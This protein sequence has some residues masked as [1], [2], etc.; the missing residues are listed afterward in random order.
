MNTARAFAVRSFLLSSVL[1]ALVAGCKP[2]VEHNPQASVKV[3]FMT[4]ARSA[5]TGSGAPNKL[6][7]GPS[8]GDLTTNYVTV[9]PDS[10]ITLF[11]NEDIPSPATGKI[12]TSDDGITYYFR[13]V[14]ASRNFTLSA[15][16]LVE[17]YCGKGTDGLTTSNGQEGFGIMAR[18]WVPQYPGRTIAEVAASLAA[19]PNA[20]YDTG[21]I[22]GAGRSNMI[23]VGGVKRGVRMAYRYGVS[24]PSG[25]CITNPTFDWNSYS[26]TIEMTW[27]P[28]E[29]GDYSAYPTLEDRPDFPAKNAT[30]RLY[31]RKTNSGFVAK[32]TPPSD[33]GGQSEY[34]LGYPDLLTATNRDKYYVGFFAA[35]SAQIKVSNIEYFEAECVDEAP[36]VDPAALV[37]TPSF[38]IVSP[39]ANSDGDYKLYCAANVKGHVSVLQDGVAVKGAENL[40]CS[41]ISDPDNGMVVPFAYFDIPVYKLADGDNVFQ[42][43]FYPG[44]D[45]DDKDQ[46]PQPLTTSAS[47]T[48]TIIVAKRSFFSAATPLYV[49]PVGNS[50]NAGTQGSPLDL[51]TAIACVLPGQ[52]ILMEDGS[53]KLPSLVIPRYNNGLYGKPKT[54]K[55]INRDQAF[56]DFEK[57]LSVTNGVEL[58]GNYWVLSGFHVRN[59]PNKVKGL[60]V[61]GNNNVI[62]WVKAYNNGDTGLQFSGRTSEPYAFWPKNNLMQYCEA[63]NNKDDSMADADGFAAKITVGDGNVFNWCVSHNNADDGWD[64]FAKKETGAIGAVTIKNCISYENGKLIDG[65]PSLS[66]RNG[67]KVGGE[68]LSTPHVVTNCL[69][70]HN[71]AHGFTSNSNPAVQFTYCSSIDNGGIYNLKTNSDS[72]NFTIYDGSN[73]VV[74]LPAAASTAGLLSLYS[75]DNSHTI[76]W[77]QTA[78]ASRK[79]DK[80]EITAAIQGYLWLG[81]DQSTKVGS[82][83]GVA[84]MNSNLAQLTIADLVSATLPL[85]AADMTTRVAT[86]GFIKRKADG[87][88][89]AEGFGNLK[90]GKAGLKTG[91]S[92]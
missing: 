7:F 13:E 1:V 81:T 33:K 55:A 44:I 20:S 57:D 32:I 9:N 10:T 42:V 30:Y 49:S 27:F 31:L 84:T 29:L 78:G 51:R 21:D 41:W 62:E 11:S 14:E 77:V 48:K 28:K 82:R 76:D 90:A 4:G 67:F 54:L 37:Y 18:D 71:G 38:S 86:C 92:F 91:C 15:D 60:T 24:E 72:R 22:A 47:I 45:K 16:I 74:G 75:P 58:Y 68:G 65:S 83:V 85:F 70:F 6:V 26:P 25:D 17:A 50:A 39:T 79:E 19:D 36:R 46:S 2:Y 66:G 88:F 34:T 59:T 3:D 63:Y 53:Y 5:G 8:T 56:I 69:A 23:M 40:Y 89:D 12:S 73:T 80:I 64:L 61:Y 87:S 35:R 52:S 43:T